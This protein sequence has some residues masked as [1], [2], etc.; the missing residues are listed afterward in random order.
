VSQAT[1]RAVVVGTGGEVLDAGRTARFPGPRLRRA[2]IARDRHCQFGSCDAPWQHCDLHHLIFWAD[3]GPT[4]R[5]NLALICARHHTLVHE[6]GWT[7]RR[8]P[9]G[10]ITTL[11]PLPR[12][13]S[14]ARP[15]GARRPLRQ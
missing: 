6:H 13:R 12:Q 4:T 9:D 7:L 2:I 11:P 3:G 14:S 10:S 15:S 5:D 8:Q 1:R